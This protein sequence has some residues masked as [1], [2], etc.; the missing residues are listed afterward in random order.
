MSDHNNTSLRQP[1]GIKKFNELDAAKRKA[2]I[3]ATHDRQLL[4]NNLAELRSEGPAVLLKNIVLP[5]VGV[6]VAIWSVSKVVSTL[7]K[8]DTRTYYVEPQDDSGSGPV[9]L[10]TRDRK[11]RTSPVRLKET[12][13]KKGKSALTYTKYIP[14]VIQL[15]KMG[16]SYMEKNGKPVPQ[17][18]HD[19]LSGPGVSPRLK[20][21]PSAQ[22][23]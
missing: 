10:A 12:A 16:V 15:A 13:P 1:E 7:T 8:P 23:A 17:V 11:G 22:Q 3:N 19:L 20:V 5:V 4:V 9:K 6:G 18:I 14:V 21:K 2:Q